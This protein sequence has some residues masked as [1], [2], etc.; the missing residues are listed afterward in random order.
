MIYGI[1]GGI[2]AVLGFLPLILVLYVLVLSLIHIFAAIDYIIHCDRRPSLL[3]VTD[4]DDARLARAEQ[5]LSPKEAEENG[6]KLVYAR[7]V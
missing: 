1:M 4:I 6:I 7:C 2:G 3:V 5:V